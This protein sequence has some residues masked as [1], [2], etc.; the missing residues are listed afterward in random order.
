[1]NRKGNGDVS[2][3]I[4]DSR[5]HGLTNAIISKSSPISTSVEI[6]SGK[7]EYEN[8]YV[9]QRIIS[10]YIN[11]HRPYAN[12]LETT[13]TKILLQNSVGVLIVFIYVSKISINVEINF[14]T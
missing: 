12:K 5:D 1:M 9:I 4:L 14:S 7:Y 13:T 11:M 8:L 10:N 3:D 6:E 2:F